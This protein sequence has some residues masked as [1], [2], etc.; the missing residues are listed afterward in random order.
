MRPSGLLL[1][2]LAH[3]WLAA[4]VQAQGISIG[5]PDGIFDDVAACVP[6]SDEGGLVHCPPS[7]VPVIE[8]GECTDGPA[9]C[10]GLS[11][12]T[13][14]VYT[15]ALV[16]IG[17]QC[18]FKENLRSDHYRNGDAI[19]GNL[20]NS[21]W[22]NTTSGAQAVY[23]NDAANLATY[24]RLYNWY[25]IQDH[26]GLCPA[27]FHVPSDGEW[28]TLEMALGMTQEQAHEWGWRGTDQG[29][30]MKSS[31][32]DSPSWDGSNTSGFSSLS[33]GYRGKFGL[34][35][36]LGGSGSWWSASP[37]GGSAIYRYLSS[38][39]SSVFRDYDH[40]QGGFA[41]RCVRD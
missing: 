15:Y 19:P 30:Q 5:D 9:Q 31:T 36:Y 29:T 13:F 2:L 12:V 27:G 22:Q 37:D 38:G 33:V 20:S 6:P 23:N 24:G 32:S 14:D 10:D 4:P 17:S 7:S 8:G 34:F 18:W 16:G 21:S 11:S 39:F 26:R 40:P 1:P 41:V 28:M 35:Y 25:A 3:F